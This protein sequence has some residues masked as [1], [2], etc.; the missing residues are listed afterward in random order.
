MKLFGVV[1]SIWN[2]THK[3]AGNIFFRWLVPLIFLFD[4]SS[5]FCILSMTLAIGIAVLN[6]SISR[7]F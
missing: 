3:T 1:L 2:L 6:V 4:F 7:E 5:G